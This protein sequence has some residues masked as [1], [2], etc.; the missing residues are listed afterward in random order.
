M[1]FSCSWLAEPL[2]LIVTVIPCVPLVSKWSDCSGVIPSIYSSLIFRPVSSCV[3]G[4]TGSTA[5][6]SLV[7]DD[8]V[9]FKDVIRS[10]RSIAAWLPARRTAGPRFSGCISSVTSAFSS[11]CDVL[12]L[13]S[14]DSIVPDRC[15]ASTCLVDTSDPWWGLETVASADSISSVLSS[16]VICFSAWDSAEPGNVSDSADSGRSG[17]DCTLAPG[18]NE[19]SLKE[20]QTTP[21][22]PGNMMLLSLREKVR[23]NWSKPVFQFRILMALKVMLLQCYHQDEGRYRKRRWWATDVSEDSLT[24]YTRVQRKS[25]QRLFKWLCSRHTRD[26]WSHLGVR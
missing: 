11:W 16:P 4:I 9:V 8:V 15:V 5:R 21:W 17:Y 18:M 19:I 26:A 10:S 1:R 23:L 12:G 22:W 3:S 14:L 25:R 20:T 13:R 24:T 6:W 2:L 7:E